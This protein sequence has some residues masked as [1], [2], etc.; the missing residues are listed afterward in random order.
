MMRPRSATTSRP[1]GQLVRN[2]L[3]FPA[4]EAVRK[5]NF[6][7]KVVCFVVPAQAGTQGFQSRPLGPRFRGGDD[8][9]GLRDLITASFAG[10]T[11]EKFET[12]GSVE[13]K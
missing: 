11:P 3:V 7:L 2:T 10:V 6:C 1:N 8:L 9:R 4:Q 5:L 12:V 13:R